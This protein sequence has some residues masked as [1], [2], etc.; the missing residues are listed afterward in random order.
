M[1]ERRLDVYRREDRF[2]CVARQDGRSIGLVHAGDLAGI[3]REALGARALE[4]LEA[5][6]AMPS[7]ERRLHYPDELLPEGW[8]VGHWRELMAEAALAVI[9]SPEPGRLRLRPYKNL[10][11]IG[12]DFSHEGGH[13]LDCSHEPG[14]LGSALR[15]ALE[16]SIAISRVHQAPGGY[17]GNPHLSDALVAELRRLGARLFERPA[18][19]EVVEVTEGFFVLPPPLRQLLFDVVWRRESRLRDRD[20][21]EWAI[22][23]FPI[24]DLGPLRSWCLM[25]V[26]RSDRAEILVRLDTKRPQDPPTFCLENGAPDRVTTLGPARAEA[27]AGIALSQWLAALE[28]VGE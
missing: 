8:D 2:V 17:L 19:P 22:R 26:A 23:W 6:R 5:A 9:E 14:A 13:A 12:E 20:G 18:R 15:A 10:S 24:T 25:S 28:A 1:S 27:P 7:P 3:D 21:T 4:W 16:V 11:P